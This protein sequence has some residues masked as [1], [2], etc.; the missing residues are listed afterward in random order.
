LEGDVDAAAD[1]VVVEVDVE[2]EEVVNFELKIAGGGGGTTLGVFDGAGAG[3]T[4]GVFAG[5]G[6]GMMFGVFPAG[7]LIVVDKVKV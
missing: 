2:V 3:T 5:A 1:D 4:F 6:A 7:A